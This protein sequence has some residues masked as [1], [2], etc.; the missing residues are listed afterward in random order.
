METDAVVPPSDSQAVRRGTRWPAGK[1]DTT[2]GCCGKLWRGN[3]NEME[4]KFVTHFILT[5]NSNTGCANISNI[6]ELMQQQGGFND[7]QH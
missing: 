5:T 4:G 6:G 3:G 2:P 1:C 7:H